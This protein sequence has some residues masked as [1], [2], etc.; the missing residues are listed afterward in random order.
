MGETDLL[1]IDDDPG[2]CETLSDIFG[3]RGYRV[4]TASTGGDAMGKVKRRPFAATL[5]D[6][7]LPDM[8]GIE[9]LEELKKDCPE[10]V[11]IIITGHASLQSAIAA[12]T[13]DADGYFVKPL[14]IEEVFR[15]LEDAL[16]KRHLQRELKESRDFYQTVV[17]NISD[18]VSVVE[19]RDFKIVSVNR[20]FLEQAGTSEENVIGETCHEITHRRFDRCRLLEHFCPLSD[21]MNSGET[22][23]HVHEHL[24]KD[25]RKVYVEVSVTPLRNEKGEVCRLLHVSREITEKI[26]A[27]ERIKQT[28][29]ALIRKNRELKEA[30]GHIK[31]LHGLLPICSFCKKIRNDDGYWEKVEMYIEGHTEAEFSHGICKECME[32]YYPDD[33]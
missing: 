21:A 1:I 10:M 8:N 30:M 6:Y 5:I 17:D 3:E 18:A 14:V 26:R 20:A 24:D 12:L 19:A 4:I 31:T 29:K 22:R 15:R 16:E 25:G 7:K 2:A 11:C 33:E 13:D 9:L 27:E 23:R 28:M 32:K